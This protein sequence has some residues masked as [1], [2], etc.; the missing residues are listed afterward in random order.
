MQQEN[1][2]ENSQIQ[3][4]VLNTGIMG[5]V[6][7]QYF[8]AGR[9]ITP[10]QIPRAK[11][12]LFLSYGRGDDDPDFTNPDKSF[13]RRLYTDL[14]AHGYTVWWDREKM[15][16][17]DLT[18]LEEIRDAV[19]DADRMLLI[20]GPYGMQSAYVRAEWEFARSRCKPI[21]PLLRLGDY[22]LI[23]PELGS[24][25]APDCRE[26]RPYAD[27]FA[28][29]LRVLGDADKPLAGLYGVPPLPIGYI[30]RPE[31]ADLK[32]AV[33]ADAVRPIVVTPREQT[34][35]LQ[36]VG[37]IGKTT[38]TAALAQECEV[39]RSFPDGVFWLEM[40]KTPSVADR[41]ADIGSIFGDVRDNYKD[42]ASA[43]LS[44]SAILAQKAALIVLDDVWA[45]TV[46]EAFAGMGGRCRIV[47]TTRQNAIANKLGVTAQ[48]LAQ[49]TEDEGLALIY[50]RLGIP[51]PPPHP[52]APG[53]PSQGAVPL[54]REEESS[55]LPVVWGGDL[56]VGSLG[57]EEADLREIIRLVHGHTLAVALAA[58]WLAERAGI[59]AVPDLLNR[60]RKGRTFEDLQL[61]DSDKNQNLELCLR[62]SYD[63]LG[64]ANAEKRADLQ[65]RY[66]ALGVFASESSFDAA[67]AQAV[68][69]DDDDFTAPDR[70]N[71]L[72]RVGLIQP[73][74]TGGRYSQHPLLR[75]YARA[76]L[77]KEGELDE[78]AARHFAYYQQL[79]G[80][81]DANNNEDRHPHISADFANIQQAWMVGLTVLPEQ[82]CDFIQALNY[83][84][85][86][87]STTLSRKDW[88]QRAY[89]AAENAGYVPG[90]ANTLRALGD[91]SV[92]LAELDAGRG[93]YD[94][95]LA[96]FEQIGAR[97]GQANTLQALGDLSVRL[98]E[99]D[100]GRGY[101]DR[102]LA[103]F[104]Q[105][106][107][108]LGQANTLQA[109]GDL[110]V[111]LAELDAGRGYYAAAM[112][113]YLSIGDRVG[114]LNTL[115]Q[116]AQLAL[117]QNN[118]EEAAEYY[119]QL[120][121]LADTLPAYRSHPVVQGWRNEYEQLIG[122]APSPQDQM[123]QVMRQL[124]ALYQQGGADAVRDMLKGQVP[125]EVIENL[126]AQLAQLSGGDEA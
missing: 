73:D 97:L 57:A 70:L 104:E 62:L 75:S 55:P 108:R 51:V 126:L 113:L 78:T 12:H 48:T 23:P 82:T 37:G 91:L 114:Q 93:Y 71:D 15:P 69:Q 119:R 111:R 81:Y 3:A 74:K 49:L 61:D 27:Q 9:S 112:Q 77:A 65:R 94:R 38:L 120:L 79:H 80:D 10:P 35:T 43:K 66:R 121:A 56:G 59:N 98:A 16:S 11:P 53:Q 64:G 89:T 115:R 85:Q 19:D 52:P 34:V 88:V 101:Y 90:Q 50:T 95:A 110:S 26:S 39:R 1:K 47:I 125:E 33:R 76:L 25:H 8:G 46:A 2:I 13:L 124:L 67:A 86:F 6:T 29:I 96:V 92:R 54:R 107:A 109:L 28:E 22:S 44:L 45:H 116:L 105:I 117:K 100:A 18:F 30:V 72:V 99:L 21:I 102:A 122:G 4:D 87:H 123:E 17:R 68:W 20:V 42:A 58:A 84:M 32:N 40:G 14:T 41:M 36:G 31:L 118:R 5:N 7:I 24:Y 103:V 60:L 106:G 63:D 83:Y